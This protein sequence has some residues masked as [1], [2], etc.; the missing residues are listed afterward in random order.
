MFHYPKE[1]FLINYPI[2]KVLDIR[3]APP[4]EAPAMDSRLMI[5]AKKTI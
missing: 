2:L 1:V 4:H 3:K 5:E